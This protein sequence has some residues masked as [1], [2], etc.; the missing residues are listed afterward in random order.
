MKLARI[1]GT[2][3]A[4]VKDPKLA[5]LTLLAADI[6]DGEGA[7]LEKAVVLADA[8]G[9]G[10]GDHVLAVAG[11]AARIAARTAGLPVDMVAAAIVDH[12]DIRTSAGTSTSSRRNK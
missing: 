2:V 3:T 5:G 8:C 11:S 9:A 1:T 10:V 12:V 7:V 6:E 4:T